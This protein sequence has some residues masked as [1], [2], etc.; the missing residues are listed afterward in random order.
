M[1]VVFLVVGAIGLGVLLLS[2]LVG[3]IGDLA[4]DA[5]GPFSVPATA[6][7][8]GGIGFG[9]AAPRRCCPATSRT[10][11]ASCWR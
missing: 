2:L 4:G 1:E 9:G 5:D 11:A 7:L 6:A 10:P 8:V 3:E